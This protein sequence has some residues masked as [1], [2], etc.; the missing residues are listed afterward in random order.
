MKKHLKN[1]GSDQTL[2]HQEC[3]KESTMRIVHVKKVIELTKS[4]MKTA[5][6]YGS[7]MYR[8]LMDARRENPGYEI[9]VAKEKKVKSCL[10]KLD[11]ATIRAYVKAH[12]TEDQKKVFLRMSTSTYT[13]DGVYMGPQPF[14]EIKKWFLIEFPE[15]TK[16][17]IDHEAE[18]Q[19]IIAAVNAKIAEAKAQAIEKAKADAKKEA[20]LFLAS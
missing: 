7:E 5:E 8:M 9:T 15:Y 4:E 3:G 2:R 11:L 18:M 19:E 6:V 13:K 12:G 1:K 20:E 14:V 16:A 17:V 10:P